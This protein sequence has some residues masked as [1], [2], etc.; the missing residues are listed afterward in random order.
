LVLV[1]LSNR[2]GLFLS[3]PPGFYIRDKIVFSANRKARQTA[4]HRY[5][6]DVGQ[7][8]R[9][10]ALKE[11]LRRHRERFMGSQIRIQCR[12]RRKKALPFLGPR[13]RL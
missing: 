2:G 7:G 3:H 4:E 12:E 5:L 11:F 8:V 9:D 13:Q 1:K 10:R 6:S